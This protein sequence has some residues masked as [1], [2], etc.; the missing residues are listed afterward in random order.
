MDDLVVII[1]TLNEALHIRRTIESVQAK[2]GCPAI[3]VVDG[4][5][6]DETVE[7]ARKA[8]AKVS[9]SVPS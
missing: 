3:C 5:S 7:L 6:S 9:F 2:S 4:G 1:P 8:G